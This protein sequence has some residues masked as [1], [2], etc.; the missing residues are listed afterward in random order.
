MNKTVADI[1]H[2][3]HVASLTVQSFVVATFSTSRLA[4]ACAAQY[5]TVNID[6][7]GLL[8]DALNGKYTRLIGRVGTL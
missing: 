7:C 2:P 4:L 8:L 1:S 6:Y 3:I 5:S